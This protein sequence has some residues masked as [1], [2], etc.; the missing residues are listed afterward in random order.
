MATTAGV[1]GTG[2]PAETER[3]SGCFGRVVSSRAPGCAKGDKRCSGEVVVP[4]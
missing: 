2:V 3:P 4:D 1:E